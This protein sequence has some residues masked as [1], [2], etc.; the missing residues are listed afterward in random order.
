MY[1]NLNENYLNLQFN[2]KTRPLVYNSE[3]P[4]RFVLSS[5]SKSF[6]TRSKKLHAGK[7]R[8]RAFFRNR[9]SVWDPLTS[10]KL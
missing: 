8:P 1:V 9:I 6:T 7:M 3:R 5:R 2:S 10:A 4:L